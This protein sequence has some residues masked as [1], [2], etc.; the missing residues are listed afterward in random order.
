M[1]IIL[2]FILVISFSW[3]SY[4]CMCSV[5]DFDQEEYNLTQEI[6]VGT[7]VEAKYDEEID[8]YLITL[9]IIKS[10]KGLLKGKTNLQTQNGKSHVS[11]C[12]FA[13]KIGETYMLFLTRE[14]KYFEIDYCTRKVMLKNMSDFKLPEWFEPYSNIQDGYQENYN[15]DNTLKS[16]GLIQEGKANGEWKFYNKYERR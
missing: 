12:N 14:S 9:D 8:R 10:Y 2:S 13:G 3:S 4:G 16:E 15:S 1:R 6:F 11:S 7:I 5:K